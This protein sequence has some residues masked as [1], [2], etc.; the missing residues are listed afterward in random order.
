[1][2]TELN[3]ILNLSS[4]G[5]ETRGTKFFIQTFHLKAVVLSSVT[6]M[7]RYLQVLYELSP[8][9]AWGSLDSVFFPGH[10]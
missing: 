6:E 4:P 1:M 10:Y 3:P 8:A 5:V 9:L 2:E 7:A